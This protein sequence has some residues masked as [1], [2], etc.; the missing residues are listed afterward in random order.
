[1][2]DWQEQLWKQVEKTASDVEEFLVDV[3]E[4]TETIVE[5]VGEGIGLFFEQFGL[6]IVEEVDSFIQNFVDVIVTTS[7]EINTALGDNLADF[8]DDDFTNVDFHT[9]SLE[10]N[11]ACINCANY[12]GQSYNGN[13][14]VCAMH[15]EGWSDD[16][17]PD[18]SDEN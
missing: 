12:H 17:C 6:D 11:P 8:I 2:D 14:L 4:A 1:M 10:N 3:E 15:P 9:A 16:N 13:L 7:D 18:W 5:E